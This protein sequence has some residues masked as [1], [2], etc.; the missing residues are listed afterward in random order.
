MPIKNV[1][2]LKAAWCNVIYNFKIFV[3]LQDTNDGTD[4]IPFL[5]PNWAELPKISMFYPPKLLGGEP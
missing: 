4:Q 5:S 2:Q 1:L 3:G